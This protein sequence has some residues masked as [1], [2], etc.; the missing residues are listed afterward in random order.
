MY[1]S[2]FQME[3]RRAVGG[4]WQKKTTTLVQEGNSGAMNDILFRCEIGGLLV[5]LT[6]V[7][8]TF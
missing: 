2:E 1:R 8:E 6:T 7:R 5:V 4:N 3:R